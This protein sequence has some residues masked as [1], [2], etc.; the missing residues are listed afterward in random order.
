MAAARWIR[1][2]EDFV[3]AGYQRV[4]VLIWTVAVA[5]LM[6]G[7]ALELLIT[8]PK[9]TLALR[10][11]FIVPL[12]TAA[13]LIARRPAWRQR[14]SI[15]V[16][17]LLAVF[18]IVATLAMPGGTASGIS[19]MWAVLT[20]ASIAETWRRS[21]QVAVGATAVLVLIVFLSPPQGVYTVGDQLGGVLGAGLGL[22]AVVT[23]GA[24]QREHVAATL[25]AEHD[26]G[27]ELTLQLQA[28]RQHLEQ[29]V[30]ER[31]RQLQQQALDLRAQQRILQDSLRERE[32]LTAQLAEMS[33]RDELTGLPNR[34]HF[35][36]MMELLHRQGQPVGI[37][38]IDV[39]HFKVI[40][41]RYGHACG[42]SVL[43]ELAGILQAH[44][45]TEDL[46]ARIGG[47]EF[48]V[49]LPGTHMAAAAQVGE[50]VRQAVYSHHWQR[51]VG[52]HR[53][54]ISVGVAD[55]GAGRAPAEGLQAADQVLYRAK[56]AGRNRVCSAAVSAAP[57][58]TPAATPARSSPS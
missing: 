43:R 37:L 15:S 39:D 2:D 8:G 56:E 12:A 23:L 14:V 40:N 7:I 58:G 50:Q 29:R 16:Y 13:A 32:R 47:E 55:A 54:T 25:V 28:T 35:T 11:A 1:A 36:A 18:A 26:R 30:A 3:A 33:S 51:L 19:A 34:R 17:S 57:E 49:L 21:L 45:G 22:V 52:E 20:A 24:R 48:V 6:G 41:D 31:T 10:A 4:H 9:W 42:D 5:A 44:V 27:N 53:V 46:P 38:A